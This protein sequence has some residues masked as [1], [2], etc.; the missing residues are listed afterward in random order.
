MLQGKH[1]HFAGDSAFHT[2]LR[3][4]PLLVG[5]TA[6]VVS[7]SASSQV[8]NLMPHN[9]ILSCTVNVIEASRGF[10][11]LSVP[12]TL[13]RPKGVAKQKIKWAMRMIV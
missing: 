10:L 6:E 2:S 3:G 13:I 11:Q 4:A 9:Y 7:P 8:Q 12:M 1:K 5:D